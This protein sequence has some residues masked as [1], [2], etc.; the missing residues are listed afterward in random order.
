MLKHRIRRV[1]DLLDRCTDAAGNGK[2]ARQLKTPQDL[3]DLLEEQIQAVGLAPWTNAL[4]KAQ[5][6]GVL[7][8]ILRKVMEFNTVSNR[9]EMLEAVL[10]QRRIDRRPYTRR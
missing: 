1:E 9:V 2:P 8:G 7:A 5:A 10:K 3:I 4:Q 6:I